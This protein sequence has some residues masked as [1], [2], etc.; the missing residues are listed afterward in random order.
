MLAT[1]TA[2][3]L[4]QSAS[5]ASPIAAPAIDIKRND[6]GEAVMTRAEIRNYNAGLPRE[7]PGYIRCKRAGETGS[8]VKKAS[9]CRTNAE[10]RQ[11][12]DSANEDARDLIEAIN[13]STSTRGD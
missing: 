11:T 7:H 5:A 2:L 1:L 6:R 3:A 8:L 4:V 13:T 12:E 9:S 10:W